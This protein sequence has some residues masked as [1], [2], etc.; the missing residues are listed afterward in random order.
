MHKRILCLILAVIS[1]VIITG[2]GSVFSATKTTPSELTALENKLAAATESREAAEAAVAEAETGY[3]DALAKKQAIDNKIYALDIEIEA[4]VAL[5]DGYNKQIEEKN[6]EIAAE[7]EKLDAAYNVVRE[8]I[9]AKREDGSIDFL[10]IIFEADGLT[11]L[12]TQI[13]RF[14]CMLEYDE[15]LLESYNNSIVNLENLKNEL[16]ESKAALDAQVKN[17]GQRKSELEADLAAAKKLVAT[18]ENQLASAE[19]D[20]ENVI[21]ME[22][23]YSKEREELLANLARTTNQSYVGG[24]FLWPLPV[25]YMKI[26]SGYG[27]RIHPVTGKPQFHRGID[28]PAPYGTEIYAVN[29]GTVVECSYNYADGYYITISHGGGIASFYSHLSRYRVNVGDKVTRGQ[30]I[31]NVGTSGYT[32]GPHLNLNVYENNSAVDPIKY[33]TKQD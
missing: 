31:A 5:I 18:S 15:Q 7:T 19:E 2:S 22:E 20:L 3:A 25:A 10:S 24:E 17:L 30:V 11:E 26:S 1:A 16:T 14:T 4:T 6:L 29:D 9:R 32:T 33:F 8:R 27:N 23:Q 13:D 21:A 12:F 28:I